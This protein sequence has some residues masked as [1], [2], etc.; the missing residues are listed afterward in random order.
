MK[1]KKKSVDTPMLQRA[2]ARML[3]E[4]IP[5]TPEAYDA[6]HTLIDLRQPTG[7]HRL[8]DPIMVVVDSFPMRSSDEI[9]LRRNA[10]RDAKAKCLHA[11]ASCEVVDYVFPEPPT[12]KEVHQRMY[13]I[14]EPQAPPVRKVSIRERLM[15][16]LDLIMNELDNGL[17]G[18]MGQR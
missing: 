3:A 9:E 7:L 14:T 8:I 5:R 17:F 18:P 11:G 10:V 16:K 4:D 12:A 13:F 1:E 2:H 15:V 6:I